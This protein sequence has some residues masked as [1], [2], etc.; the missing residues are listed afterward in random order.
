MRARYAVLLVLSP[1]FV[2]RSQS[3]A[4]RLTDKEL[5]QL[6][7]DFSEAN[8]Y[9]R[10]DNF[11]SNETGF[12]W[13]V[14]E[15]KR[16]IPPGGVYLGVGPEQNFTYIVALQPKIAFIF[17]IRRG[18]MIAHLM[19]KALLETSNDRADFLSKLFSRP[20]PAGLD[21]SSTPQQLFDAY[22]TAAPD[23]ALFR[24]NLAD[25]KSYL[26]KTHGFVMNDSDSKLMD[27]TYGAFFGGG[28]E[29]NYSYPNRFGGGFGRGGMPTYAT[30]QQATDSA[31]KNWAYLA[32]EANYRWLKDFESKNLLVPVVGDFAGPKAIRSV[33]QYLKDHHAIAS[34]FYTSNVEQYLWQQA[35]EAQRFY[36]N[37]AT[38]PLDSTSTFIRSIGGGFRGYNAASSYPQARL[39]GRLPSVTSSIQELVN[40]FNSGKLMSYG[41]VIAMSR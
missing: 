15:L 9:F 22:I 10:S 39:G 29:L 17:D 35:D 26:T 36:R 38:L 30:L 28:P 31:G 1:V 27:Y 24:R 33:A 3:I 40:A 18:N 14:P 34:A 23:S 21:T 2:A 5:W 25:V 11:L 12:Q 32:T 20:R 37:V 7:S 4:P 41:D 6:N 19:Y 16:R 8:G 13:V